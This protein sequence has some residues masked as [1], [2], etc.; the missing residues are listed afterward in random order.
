MS[1]SAFLIAVVSLQN[2]GFNLVHPVTPTFIGVMGMQD[3]IFGV[4]YA[5]MALTSFLFSKEAGELAMRR[6]SSCS[7]P[8]PTSPRSSSGDC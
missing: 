4:S 7:S 5:A 3:W 2:L 1:Q 8:R 6:C